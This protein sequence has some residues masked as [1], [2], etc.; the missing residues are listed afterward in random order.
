MV[1]LELGGLALCFVLNLLSSRKGHLWKE[2]KELILPPASF[3]FT[4]YPI[5]IALPEAHYK[6]IKYS[7]QGGKDINE[8]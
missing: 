7:E 2:D 4:F 6:L 1:V 5:I 8:D 3:L